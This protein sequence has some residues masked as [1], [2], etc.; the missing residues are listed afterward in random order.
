MKRFTALASGLSATLLLIACPVPTLCQKPPVLTRPGLAPMTPSIECYVMATHRYSISTPR[1]CYITL[2][3]ATPGSPLAITVPKDTTVQIRVA[4]RSATEN[5]SFVKTED[6]VAKPDWLLALT[7][8]FSPGIQTITGHPAGHFA[9]AFDPFNVRQL[10]A[11][12]GH[13]GCHGTLQSDQC[14]ARL[15]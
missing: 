9:A 1:S 11:T 8:Q 15:L 10:Q 14:R 7:K 12:R 13:H 4:G 5:I 3:E 6:A 2:T